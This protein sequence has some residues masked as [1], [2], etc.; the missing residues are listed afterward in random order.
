MVS[1]GYSLRISLGVA[2]A[3]LVATNGY[4]AYNAL[5]HGVSITYTRETLQD[6]RAAM[7][8][9]V[10]LVNRGDISSA[11]IDELGPISAEAGS[12]WMAETMTVRAVNGSVVVSIEDESVRD[13]CDA[14]F[15][16]HRSPAPPDHE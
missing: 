9:L 7:C 4:W 3:S 6:Y 15:Q 11:A 12:N 10:H 13:L 2:I 14:L 8:G 16:T 5:D 1:T